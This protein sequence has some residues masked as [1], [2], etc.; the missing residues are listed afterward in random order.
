MSDTNSADAGNTQTTSSAQ[1]VADA[2]TLGAGVSTPAPAS[3]ADA[4][5]SQQA[6]EGRTSAEP[7]KGGEAN[8]EGDKPADAVESVLGAPETYEFKPPEGG[9]FDDEVI[10]T[11]SEVVKDLDLSQGAAQKILDA[12]APK[13]AERFQARQ[14]EAYNTAVS[15][16]VTDTKA[17]KTL[18]GDK[19]QENLA[20]AEKA[21]AAFGTPELRALL[22]KFDMQN[23]PKGTGLGNHPEIIRAFF[24][25]GKAISEDKFVPGGRQPTK[26]ETTHA[27]SLYPNQPA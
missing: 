21:L 17:D 22:G 9:K 13:V 25:A 5:T 24:N 16:W 2:A 6:P 19:L 3:L 18:G 20:V 27:K 10:G 12:I 15:Q 11:F 8:P 7:A 14:L 1:P 4:T 23:N 26:G